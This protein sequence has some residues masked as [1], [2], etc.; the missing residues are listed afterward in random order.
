[1]R[2]LRVTFVYVVGPGEKDDKAGLCVEESRSAPRCFGML[3]G[4]GGVCLFTQPMNTHTPTSTVVF[5]S[6]ISQ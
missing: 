4:G 1:M 6:L 3:R 2:P 5:F